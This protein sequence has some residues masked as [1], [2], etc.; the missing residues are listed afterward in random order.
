MASYLSRKEL[1]ARLG[2]NPETIRRMTLAQQIPHIR[3]GNSFRYDF[4]EVV[5]VFKH[6]PE[7]D[8]TPTEKSALLG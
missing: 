8:T 4:D 1:A 2:L 3:V 6:G 5:R 7:A